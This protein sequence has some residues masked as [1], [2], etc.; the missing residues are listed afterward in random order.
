MV[1]VFSVI[2]FILDLKAALDLV[3][4]KYEKNH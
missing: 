2:F 4:L 1:A 3:S